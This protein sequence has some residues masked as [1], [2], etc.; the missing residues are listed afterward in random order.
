M[1]SSRNRRLHPWPVV[2]VAIIWA[3]LS[4]CSNP[5]QPSAAPVPPETTSE[6]SGSGSPQQAATRAQTCIESRL[7]K[8]LALSAVGTLRAIMVF[9][10]FP[11]APQRESTGELFNLMAP[12]AMT[13]YSQASYGRLKLEIEASAS[14]IRMPR[15]LSSY[16]PP[17]SLTV[18]PRDYFSDVIGV[19][20]P[21]IDFSAFDMVLVVR[22]P[23]TEIYPGTIFSAPAGSGII[24]DGKELRHAALLSAN[25]SAA[26][27]PLSMTHEIGHLLGL[28]DLYDGRNRGTNPNAS[29]GFVGA[30]D[31][32]GDTRKGAHFMAWNTWKL[33]WLEREQVTCIEDGEVLAT[34]TPLE[35]VGG[36]KAVFIR[37]EVGKGYSIEV[38]ED[39]L[40]CSSGV[41]ISRIDESASSGAGPVQVIAVQ[42]SQAAE[43][44]RCGELYG[45]VLKAPPSNAAVFED[46]GLGLSVEV[47][48][49][50]GS[51]F[52]V[53]VSKVAVPTAGATPMVGPSQVPMSDTLTLTFDARLPPGSVDGAPAGLTPYRLVLQGHT[54]ASVAELQTAL[55]AV[56]QLPDGV[57]IRSPNYI[58]IYMPPGTPAQQ[59]VVTIRL[60]DGRTASTSIDHV[61]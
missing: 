52:G 31:I 29:H 18:V 16:K 38:R 49:A 20:D 14:W 50:T 10:D 17:S 4:A 40:L 54:F 47:L 9:V 13:W 53:R 21:V 43:I 60:P 28:P 12:T 1:R 39:S 56:P 45:A 57:G 51:Q 19:S 30:W 32:M 26:V 48:S 55:S 36:H 3:V 61:P 25:L 6:P 42:E 8:S 27:R 2:L 35:H 11:D 5:P 23:T 41:L 33:G 37:T 24:A 59:Y 58:L 22:P 44:G 34:L 46:A 15:T 7:N